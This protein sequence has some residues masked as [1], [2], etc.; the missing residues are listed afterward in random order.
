MALPSLSG[1]WPRCATHGG[2]RTSPTPPALPALPRLAWRAL[3]KGPTR[4][5]R[6]SLAR[7][8]PRA[9]RLLAF[10]SQR[11][12]AGR[13]LPPPS[14]PAPTESRRRRRAR[15]WPSR[16]GEARAWPRTMPVRSD[17]TSAHLVSLDGTATPAPASS[18]S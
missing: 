14:S 10:S 4:A 16:C 6:P 5:V 17:T 2:T 12:P 9:L 18:A 11:V 7:A 1:R 3:A 13:A 15:S 8:V